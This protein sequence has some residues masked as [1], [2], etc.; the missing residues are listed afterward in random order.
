MCFYLPFHLLR[1]EPI[2]PAYL[3]A[4]DSPDYFLYAAFYMPVFIVLS[5]I[6]LGGVSYVA[7]RLSGQGVWRVTGGR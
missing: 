5:W 2:T 3:Q 7:L 6:Y 1:F 4:F